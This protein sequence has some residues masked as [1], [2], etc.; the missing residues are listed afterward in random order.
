MMMTIFREEDKNDSKVK[1]I[2]I[3]PKCGSTNISSGYNA[4]NHNVKDYCDDCGFNKIDS[5]L[6]YF[7]KINECEVENFREKLKD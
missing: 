2:K 7:P 1:L 4:L 5:V 3:C 6:Q